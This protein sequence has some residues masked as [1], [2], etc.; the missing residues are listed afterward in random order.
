MEGPMARFFANP[1][2]R[3]VLIVIA[4]GAAVALLVL[5][6]KTVLV[7]LPKTAINGIVLWA[8]VAALTAAILLVERF[9]V[10]RGPSEIGF[11][12]RH[13]LRDASLGVAAGAF[14]FS[15][16]MV[17]LWLVR[18]YHIDAMHASMGLIDAAIWILPGAALEEL[19]FRGIL[20][21]LLAEWSGTWVALAIS[22]LVFGAVHIGNPGSSW[23][24]AVSIV[25]EAGVLLAAAFIV[26]RS[27]WAPIGLH[28][29]WNFFEGPVYG[30]NLSGLTLQQPLFTSH[31]TGPA[32]LTGGAFGPEASV[33][34]IL[35]CS[36]AAIALLVYAKRDGSI[37]P[38]PWFR[39]RI[40]P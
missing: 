18:A 31:L 2:V 6:A 8:L 29:A 26:T 36:A 32:W 13:L 37:V 21:R 38:C 1:L 24:A 25:L 5:A 11:D 12:T 34:A 39:K 14:L 19:L 16:I 10:K 40:T 4:F 30:T 27:L 3:L 20:F 9:T 23:F 15:A 28:F 7:H 22:S 35:T 33:P 17:E